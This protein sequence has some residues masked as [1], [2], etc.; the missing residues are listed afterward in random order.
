VD[1][2]VQ[3]YNNS[4]NATNVIWDMGDGNM[5]Y[6]MGR[7]DTV[8][9]YNDTGLLALQLI[10]QNNQGCLDTATQTI[11]LFDKVF[12]A[13]PSGFTPNG[14]GLNDVFAPVCNGVA[15]YTLTIYN[16][17]GQVILECENCSWDGTYAGTVLSQDVYMYKLQIQ[18]DSHKKKLTYGTVGIVK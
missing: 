10:A 15:F 1:E 13:I 14:D 9:K 2:L 11:R 6:P 5:L 8:Y 12:C 16:R 17:W 7:G 3:L 18:A 4:R